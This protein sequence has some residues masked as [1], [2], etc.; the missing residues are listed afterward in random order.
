MFLSPCFQGVRKIYDDRIPIQ[1]VTHRQTRNDECDIA[2]SVGLKLVKVVVED[3]TVRT[4]AAI[5]T[6]LIAKD[7][8]A[9]SLVVHATIP[10]N[11]PWIDPV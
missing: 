4:L 5:V 7:E 2:Q 10:H 1:T 9:Q 3:P 6:R 8:V 11:K